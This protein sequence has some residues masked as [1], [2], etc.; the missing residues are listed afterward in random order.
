MD[1]LQLGFY[2]GLSILYPYAPVYCA[3]ENCL[4]GCYGIAIYQSQSAPLPLKY[5]W[6]EAGPSSDDVGKS[7]GDLSKGWYQWKARVISDER[8]SHIGATRICYWEDRGEPKS[9]ND[10]DR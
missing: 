7:G 1:A 3:K 5:K 9:I 4:G 8:A 6:C 2:C 10:F